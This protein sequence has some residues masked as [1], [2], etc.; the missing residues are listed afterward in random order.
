MLLDLL[1]DTIAKSFLPNTKINFFHLAM[2]QCLVCDQFFYSEIYVGFKGLVSQNAVE[3]NL[4]NRIF[5]PG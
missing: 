1:T 5:F 4:V 2:E 3:L